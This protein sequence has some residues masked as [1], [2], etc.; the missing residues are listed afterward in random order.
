[1]PPLTSVWKKLGRPLFRSDALEKAD[2]IFVLA[3]HRNRKLHAAELF[4]DGWAPR[5][6]MSTGNPAYIA[7]VLDQRLPNSVPPNPQVRSQLRETIGAGDPPSRQYFS[8]LDNS[9]WSTQPIPAGLFGT[10]SEIRALAHWLEQRPSIRL[11]LIVSAGMHL[12]RVEFCCQRLLP[13]GCRLRF[14]AV[15]AA[16]PDPRATPSEEAPRR[17]LLEWLKVIGY[18]VLLGF[19]KRPPGPLL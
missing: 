9:E 3:G 15:P 12:K 11:I 17:I 1:M 10:L 6:L 16:G 14:I 13:E 2:L 7:Q 18:Q 8:Y 5:V 19:S 4:R